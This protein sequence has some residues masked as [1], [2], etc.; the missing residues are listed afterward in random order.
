MHT[1]GSR[2]ILILVVSGG[3]SAGTQ[4]G[5]APRRA[6]A[7]TGA[8]RR[9]KSRRPTSAASRCIVSLS[10]SA[11]S[12][13]VLRRGRFAGVKAEFRMSGNS[14]GLRTN[15]GNRALFCNA[16][17]DVQR[18]LVGS[19]G[20]PVVST[21]ATAASSRYRNT[22]RPCC[23]VGSPQTSDQDRPGSVNVKVEPWPTSLVADSTAVQ[24]HEFFVRVSRAPYLRVVPRRSR[25]AGIPGRRQILGRDADPGVGDRNLHGLRATRR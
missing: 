8:A 7:A 18:W 11:T 13:R 21:P 17:G 1:L 3:V 6:A 5:R 4:R 22:G 14:K 12:R 9:T 20:D 25:P 24:L 10:Q 2:T 19:S 16:E 15:A 23:H